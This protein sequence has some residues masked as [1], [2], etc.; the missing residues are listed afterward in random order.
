LRNI[1]TGVSVI[2]DSEDLHARYDV[3][4]LSLSNNDSV[5]TWADETGNGHDLTAG[6][7]PT[8]IADGID[9]NPV[10]RFG[11]VDE[12]L[13]VAFST[14]SQP[15]SVFIL[16]QFQSFDSND[17]NFVTG[18]ETGSGGLNFTSDMTGNDTYTINSGSSIRGGTVDT[19][20]SIFSNILDGASSAMRKNGSQIASG[21]A[22]GDGMQGL[23]VGD[24][25]SGAENAE[26]DVVEILV[27]P[28]DKSGI[29]SDVE[30]YLDRDTNI[31]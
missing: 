3:R 13:D 12:F 21:D 6:T 15:Y 23:S 22:G 14:I 18:P 7:A 2:P 1:G 19:N 10:V 29:Q 9:G 26:I 28:Q 31:L 20:P 24:N 27:Y 25:G 30:E 11:G 17:L 16:F 4:V 8:Y 5:T